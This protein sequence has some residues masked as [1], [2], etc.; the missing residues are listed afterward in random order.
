MEANY[1]SSFIYGGN[2]FLYQYFKIDNKNIHYIK[3]TFIFGLTSY[4]ITVPRNY[5]R[6][7]EIKNH[8]LGCTVIISYC[9]PFHNFDNNIIFYGI[10]KREGQEIKKLLIHGRN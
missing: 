5:I 9:Y 3:D 2:L 1:K 8:I 6:K 7:L 4:E 10:K